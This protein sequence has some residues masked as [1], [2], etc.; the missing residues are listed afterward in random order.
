MIWKFQKPWP[1]HKYHIGC[2]ICSTASHKLSMKRM[3][4]TGFGGCKVT[5]DGE[6]IYQ[7]DIHEMEKWDY[8]Y[9][10]TAMMYERIAAKDP[11]HD[12]RIA[13]YGP[14]HEEEYQRQ[15]PGCWVMIHSGPGFA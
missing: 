12:W 4:I 13:F 10:I 7:E 3:L 5:R 1:R 2:I 11:E 9:P 6:I 14:M 8:D 15:G